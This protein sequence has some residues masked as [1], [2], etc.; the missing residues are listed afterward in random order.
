MRGILLAGGSASRLRPVS[1]SLSKQMLPVYDKP[2]IYYPLSTLLRAGITEI[3]IISTAAHLPAF[4]SLLGNGAELGIRLDYAVQP[5]PRGIAEALS[6]GADFIGDQDVALILGDNVFCDPDLGATLERELSVLDGCTLFGYEVPDPQRYGV[7]VVDAAGRVTDL[8]EKP[9]RP[10][11]NLAVTGLYLYRNE[12]L[13]HVDGLA[14]SGRGELEITD[15]N[16]VF[17]AQGRARLAILPP[18]SMWFDTGTIDSL[19]EAA[20]Y[21]RELAQNQ[22]V[23]LGYVEEAALEAGLIGARELDALIRRSPV[24]S[25]YERRLRVLADAAR[26]TDSPRSPVVSGAAT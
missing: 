3:L 10:A 24:S 21:V 12:V 20:L 4:R 11:S 16:R 6:I 2:M 5:R 9:A 15:L 25:E 13:R 19:L 14:P 1:N 26:G 23:H 17:V 18:E 8:E 7:A 22:G